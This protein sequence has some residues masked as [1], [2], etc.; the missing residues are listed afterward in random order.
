MAVL[1]FDKSIFLGG[2]QH[3]A[4]SNQEIWTWDIDKLRGSFKKNN[5]N[6]VSNHFEIFGHCSAAVSIW[7]MPTSVWEKTKHHFTQTIIRVSVCLWVF[8]KSFR[9]LWIPSNTSFPLRCENGC[10][11]SVRSVIWAVEWYQKLVRSL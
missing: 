2:G 11:S 3:K 9:R 8:K 5:N 10:K 1:K 4:L 6:K 7:G